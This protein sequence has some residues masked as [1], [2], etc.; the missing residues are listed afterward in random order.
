[1]STH[2]LTMASWIVVALYASLSVQFSLSPEAVAGKG[3]MITLLP[4]VFVFVHGSIA[5]R[6]RDVVFFA[7]V[8]MIVSNLSE[9]TSILTGFPFGR[10]YYTDVLGPKLFLVPL[11]VGPAYLGTGYLSWMLARVIL[12]ASNP[13]IEGRFVFTMPLLASF[14]MV[15]WDLAMDPVT[16]TINRQWIWLDG[17]GYFGIPFSNFTGWFLTV[18]VFFQIFA[19]YLQR[20][21]EVYTGA[22]PLSRV[23]WLQAVLAYAVTGLKFPLNIVTHASADTIADATGALWRTQDIYLTTGL[24]SLFTMYAFV[25]LSVVKLTEPSPS[26]RPLGE[27]RAV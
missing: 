22:P 17:G 6:F 20:Y 16:A 18:Y 19:L 25:V 9:N 27:A 23:Y 8:T 21:R 24:V 2:R 12:G 14:I 10:Y 3:A 26:L 13:A 4:L 7:A 1:M 5:Y 15:S 11:L